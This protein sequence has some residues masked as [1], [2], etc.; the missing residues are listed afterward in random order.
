MPKKER[1]QFIKSEHPKISITRQ[2]ELLGLSRAGYYY[3]PKPES[4]KNIGLMR[5]ID[6][7]YTKYPYYG[8]PKITAQLNREKEKVNHKRIERLMGVMGIQAIRPK[9]NLSKNAKKHAKYPYLL[10]K[11]DINHPNHVWGTDITYIRANGKWFYLVA[12]LDW[13]SR[14][15]ISW[16]LSLSLKSDFCIAC[17]KEA[18]TIALPEINNSDQGVQFTAEDYL[19]ILEAHESIKISMDGRGR[20]F[21]NIFTERLWRNVKYE[22]VYLKEYISFADTEQ[23]LAGYF[24]IYNYERIHENLNYQTPAEIY[25]NINLDE[26]RKN[27]AT[28]SSLSPEWVARRRLIPE[29]P[30]HFITPIPSTRDNQKVEVSHINCQF[31]V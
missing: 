5:R 19:A 4:E 15:V 14:Y 22:E 8:V 27:E 21:D 6:E 17:L 30:K 10:N 1:H 7:I 18:L 20:C 24:H 31:T 26:P 23:S 11:V 29:S 9:K 2:C 13:Y 12:I 3:R 16:K 28:E 25:F